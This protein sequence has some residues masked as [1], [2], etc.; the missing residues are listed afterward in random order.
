MGVLKPRNRLVSFRLTQDE[1]ENLRAACLMLGARNVSDFARV[2]VLDR[3]EE[4]LRPEAQLFDR[5]LALELRLAEIEI[6]VRHNCEIL[7]ARL[8]S[9]MSEP[10]E[11]ARF[12]GV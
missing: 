3:A 2:A 7:Q 10:I 9:S 5:F 4:H 1:L 12:K 11:K 6:G 8:E